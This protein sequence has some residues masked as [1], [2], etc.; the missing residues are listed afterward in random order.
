[1]KINTNQ[2]ECI[3]PINIDKI[4]KAVNKFEAQLPKNK[5]LRFRTGMEVLTTKKYSS[6]NEVIRTLNSKATASAL[7]SRVLRLLNDLALILML[8]KLL[9]KAIILESKGRIFLNL[10]HTQIGNF[11]VASISLQIGMSRG[12]PLFWQINEGPRNPA[13]KPILEELP[14]L[15]DFMLDINPDLKPVIVGDRFFASCELMKLINDE[16]VEFIFRTKTD[17]LI[18][19]SYGI[20]PIKEMADYDSEVEYKD[21][22]LRLIMSSKLIKGE[23]LFLLTNIKSSELSRQQ[24]LNKYKDRWDCETFFKDLKNSQN[25]GKTRIRKALSLKVILV[26]KSLTWILLFSTT[27]KR[28]L[29]KILKKM[30]PK[31]RLSWFN[32]AFEI[33]LKILATF[34]PFWSSG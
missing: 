4:V 7:Q 28:K 15:L 14:A 22:K 23:P 2:T 18:E 3:M 10:D 21:E 32:Y 27:N 26:F 30:H 9:I 19:T 11:T 17:K 20:V 13:M 6:L 5:R 31:K 16:G 1:M 33:F 24:V 12:L 25:V 34:R 8:E 29:R